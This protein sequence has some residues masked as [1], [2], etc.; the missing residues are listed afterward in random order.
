LLGLPPPDEYL[1]DVT[2]EPAL[3][4]TAFDHVY[5]GEWKEKQDAVKKFCPVT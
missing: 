1:T 4:Y 5:K 2:G 3:G